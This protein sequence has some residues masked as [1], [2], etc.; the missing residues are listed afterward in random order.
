MRVQGPAR[1]LESR[2]T[3]AVLLVATLGLAGKALSAGGAAWE[4]FGHLFLESK[5]VHVTTVDF[6]TLTLTAPFWVW[7]DASVRRYQGPALLFALL[8]LLGPVLW[9]NVRPRSE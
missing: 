6:V 4:D 7:N 8:P 1:A 9:L 3:A 2:V 5:F